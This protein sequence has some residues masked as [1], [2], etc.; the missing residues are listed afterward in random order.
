MKV[1]FCTGD[2][3]KIDG[4]EVVVNGKGEDLLEDPQTK[5]KINPSELETKLRKNPLIGNALVTQNPK[6]E[7]IALILPEKEIEDLDFQEKREKEV[8]EELLEE[9]PK[10]VKKKPIEK[11]PEETKKKLKKSH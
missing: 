5:E 7:L 6:G 3:G 11:T 2:V 10:A 1:F 9:R 8:E 4:N